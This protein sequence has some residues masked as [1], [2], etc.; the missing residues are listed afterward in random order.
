MPVSART[1]SESERAPST[2]FLGLD[3]HKES[4]TIAVL[5]SDAVAPAHV[6]K[7]GYDLKKLR[8]YL[9]THGP[10]ASL[11]ACYQPRA[12]ATCCSANPPRGGAPAQGSRRR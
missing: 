6:D 8:R 2:L 9:E 5:P 1:V 10:A 7:L 4:V 11:R 12:P 3:V